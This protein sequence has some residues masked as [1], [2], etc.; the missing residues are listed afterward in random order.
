MRIDGVSRETGPPSFV[1]INR[2]Y[3]HF[4]VIPSMILTGNDHDQMT[5]DSKRLLIT[6][7]FNRVNIPSHLF[8]LAFPHR[9]LTSLST[10]IST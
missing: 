4:L 1:Y 3:S 8:K 7:I 6:D 9:H 10:S 2:C 5:T